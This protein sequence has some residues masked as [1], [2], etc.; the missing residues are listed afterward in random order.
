MI[1][2]IPE[3]SAEEFRAR[4]VNPGRPVIITGA[5]ESWPARHKW[6]IIYFRSR[7]EKRRLPVA[8]VVDRKVELAKSGFSFDD[9]AGFGA[10]LGHLLDAETTGAS[11][12]G[13]VTVNPEEHLPELLDDLR[14]PAFRPKARWSLGGFWLSGSDVR[15]PLHMDL[16]DNLFAQIVGRKRVT[17]FAPR[18]ELWMYRSPPWSS[19]P[20]ISRVDSENPDYQRFP[21]FRNARGIRFILAPGELLYLPR[22][23]WHQMR[24]LETSVSTNHWWAAGAAY[25]IVR[26]GLLYQRTRKLRY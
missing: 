4:Y 9:G 18:N 10:F 13:Y 16:P 12:N 23:W 14:I 8:R 5:M 2:R 24:S 7:F 15:T 6:S 22:Y 1:E 21:R 26:L 11:C 3:P 17:L 20:Q 25:L 19:G